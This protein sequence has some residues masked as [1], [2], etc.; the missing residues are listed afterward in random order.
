M[1]L[2]GDARSEPTI[3]GDRIS[4]DA[5]KTWIWKSSVSIRVH[6]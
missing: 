6:G 3:I 1:I 2:F 5:S 4:A